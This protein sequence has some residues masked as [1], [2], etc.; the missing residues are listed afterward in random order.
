MNDKKTKQC[1]CGI[2]I[3]IED[4]A[5]YISRNQSLTPSKALTFFTFMKAGRGEEAVEKFEGITAEIGSWALRSHLCNI[6]V[7]SEVVSAIVE[8]AISYQE[9][10][11]K[12]TNK[13]GYIKWQIFSVDKNRLIWGENAI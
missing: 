9:N 10:P 7:H 1:Y 13:G 3:C 4:Q 8:T 11:A 6:K 5:S 2:E 12:I